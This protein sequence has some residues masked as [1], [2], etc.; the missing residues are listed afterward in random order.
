MLEEHLGYVADGVR[1][2]AFRTAIARVLRPGDRV[3][4]LGCG[5]GVL[6]L[7]CLQAGASQ[8]FSIDSTPMIEVARQT[9]TRAGF[10]ERCTFIHERSY[11]ATLPEQVDVVICDHVGYF[12]F[13]YGVAHTMQDARRRFLAP[14]GRMIPCRIHLEIAAVESSTAR[15]KVDRWHAQAVPAEF[16][17]L[18]HHAAN[19]KHSIELP[20]DAL[21]GRPVRLGEID[22]CADSPEFLRWTATIR[23]ERDGTLH[24]IA[25]WFDCELADGITMTN[26]PLAD[27]RIDRS[28]AFL[29]IED[30]VPVHAGD[31][32]KASV[33]ARPADHLLAWVI[34]I[35]ATGMRESHST[36]PGM[37]SLPSDLIRSRPDHVPRPSR[38]GRACAIVLGYC[39][40]VRT[41]Q[42]IAQAVLRDHPDLFPSPEE[43]ARFVAQT[44]GRDTE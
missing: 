15:A 40:G 14:G 34:E 39:D 21:L 5:S 31:M 26:S 3:A 20:R 27:R 7:L 11:R 9:M 4:D 2:E 6:G 33:M 24:G 8:V 18:R 42:Q 36:W 17:W 30:P 16:H 28:Q 13:D 10:A 22:L 19:T 1:L 38:E 43:T 29:P 23:I 32:V 25:G 44:L 12:G 37:P 41:V 35:P